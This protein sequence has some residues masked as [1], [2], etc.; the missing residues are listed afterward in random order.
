MHY[1]EPGF[2]CTPFSWERRMSTVDENRL[3]L[4]VHHSYPPARICYNEITITRRRCAIVDDRVIKIPQEGAARKK[5]FVLVVD[6]NQRDAT[7]LGILLQNLGYN[8]TVARS[9]E[10]ALEVISI[11]A[12]AL[13]ITELVLPGMNGSDLFDRITRNPAIPSAPVIIATRISNME[14]EDRCRRVGCAGYLNKP[15]QPADL[16]R[17]VQQAL[18]PTPR[19]NIRITTSL[20]ASIDGQSTSSEC[21]TVLSDAGLFV[22]TLE[23]RPNG[24]KHTVTFLL[25]KRIIRADAVVL[26]AYRFEE[27]PGKEPGMGMKFLNLSP[28]DQDVIQ[29]YIREHVSP[30]IAPV[31]KR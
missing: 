1:T 31:D 13:V 20:K 22:R 6:N 11:A 4:P 3:I 10:E 8:S 17:A 29:S 19:Q 27:N 12:P 7:Y 30:G 2:I 9:G 24:S 23:P 21:V 15:V 5:R 28:I 25:D 14:S 18:E 26:Y 16:Y